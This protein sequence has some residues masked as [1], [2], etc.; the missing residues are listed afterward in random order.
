MN[1][2]EK[3]GIRHF[4]VDTTSE[5]DRFEHRLCRRCMKTEERK[6][7]INE[8]ARTNGINEMKALHGR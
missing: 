4:W 6:D 2:C 3:E 1:D 5:Q 7:R 8:T